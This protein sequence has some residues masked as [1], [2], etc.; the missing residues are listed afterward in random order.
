MYYYYVVLIDRTSGLGHTC[1]TIY[2]SIHYVH[3]HIF[4]LSASKNM[5]LCL[6]LSCG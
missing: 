4:M 3:P 6:M 5:P 1:A 2:I